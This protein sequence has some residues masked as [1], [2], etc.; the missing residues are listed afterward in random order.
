MYWINKLIDKLDYKRDDDIEDIFFSLVDNGYEL[1]ITNILCSDNFDFLF[2]KK[3]LLYKKKLYQ[4]YN[5]KLLGNKRYYKRNIDEEIEFLNVKIIILKRLKNLNFEIKILDDFHSI[6]VY[7]IDDIVDNEI[8][9]NG[10]EKLAKS[11]IISI[12]GLLIK[13]S[14]F[15][16]ISKIRKIDDNTLIMNLI[17][18][19][20][21]IDKLYQFI[22]KNRKVNTNFKFNI[23]KSKLSDKLDFL[24]IKKI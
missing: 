15:N 2:K 22:S 8:I 17:N 11:N 23:H 24:E 3:D 1:K 5:I 13:L 9:F 16:K 7:H 6:Y 19:K 10:N 20:Y 18:D 14:S 21:D 4:C 12:D